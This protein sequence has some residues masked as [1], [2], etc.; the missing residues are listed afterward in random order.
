MKSDNNFA[1]PIWNETQGQVLLH[2]NMC[3]LCLLIWDIIHIGIQS[4]KCCGWN[5]LI[6]C[7]FC[8]WSRMAGLNLIFCEGTPRVFLMETLFDN[9]EVNTW[10]IHYYWIPPPPDRKRDLLSVFMRGEPLPSTTL[11]VDL[12]LGFLCTFT[13]L[14]GSV[15]PQQLCIDRIVQKFKAMQI[16]YPAV[17]LCINLSWHKRNVFF[18]LETLIVTVNYS[19]LFIF[20]GVFGLYWIYFKTVFFLGGLNPVKSSGL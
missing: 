18:I 7:I 16:T 20:I 17:P 5:F 12:N 6:L 11:P 14:C 13:W 15:F 9:L 2:V 4:E 10:F 3:I 19:N 8:W 1:W